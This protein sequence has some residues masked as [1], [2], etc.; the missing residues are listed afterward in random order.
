MRAIEFDSTLKFVKDK[1][2]PEA[3]K[4]EALIKVCMAGI[5]NTD[6]EI[7]KGYMGFKGVLGHEFVG[8]VEKI[9]SDDKKLLNKRVVGEINCYCGTCDFCQNNLKTHCPNRD[10]LG[11][12]GKNGCF[13]DY[14]TLPI[15]NL[16]EVADSVSDEEAVFVEPIAA[17][18]E[19]LDQVHIKPTDK[20]LVLGDGKLGLIISL[21]LNL[22]K[23]NLLLVG[24]HQSKL[25]IVANQGVKNVLLNDLCIEKKYDIVVDATGSASGFELAQNL[26][27]PR[28]YIVLKSTV[29]EC[30]NISL[31][32]LVIDEISLI[33]SRC[34]PFEPA[35][36]ALENKLIDVKPMI[37]E[38]FKFDK[39][40]KAMT[41]SMQKGCMKVIIDFRQ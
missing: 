7:M 9:N 31:A 24:K 25:D 21:V 6:I 10:V 19:I 18:F 12:L 23:A 34:G 5:C 32:P 16:I 37:S 28:G 17:A 40:D 39:A 27:S 30:K 4:G 29:A 1:V 20:V 15:Q 14:I 13:A 35:I 26:V 41:A 38:I 36:R 11:I 33:G 3:K 8:I 22:T 2:K